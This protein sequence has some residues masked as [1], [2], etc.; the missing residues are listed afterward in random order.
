MQLLTETLISGMR[1]RMEAVEPEQKCIC[2]AVARWMENAAC[3]CMKQEHTM[4]SWHLIFQP[5]QNFHKLTF[6]KK[7]TPSHN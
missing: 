1:E 2:S 3:N 5:Y 7:E 6:R 4:V